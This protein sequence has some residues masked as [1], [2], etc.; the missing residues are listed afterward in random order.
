[1]RHRCE[2]VAI[3]QSY[4]VLLFDGVTRL[5]Q[6]RYIVT[7]NPSYAHT[8]EPRRDALRCTCSRSVPNLHLGTQGVL[9]ERLEVLRRADGLALHWRDTAVHIHAGDPD[10]LASDAVGM[11][12]MLGHVTD[13]GAAA[14][15]RR[16]RRPMHVQPRALPEAHVVGWCKLKPTLKA[17][18]S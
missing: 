16:A 6:M 17:T 5:P 7:P 12:R 14:A 9:S 1:M 13:R 11:L 3:L 8:R 15:A 4:N 18:G 10:S 2:C